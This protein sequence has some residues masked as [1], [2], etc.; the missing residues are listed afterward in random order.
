MAGEIPA[1]P[2]NSR[3]SA[4]R[5]QPRGQFRGHLV[6]PILLGERPEPLVPDPHGLS[7]PATWQVATPG[8]WFAGPVFDLNTE[9]QLA[10]GW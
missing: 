6:R 5:V 9:P 3:D 10:A 4:C 7:S 1:L 2:F 8:N